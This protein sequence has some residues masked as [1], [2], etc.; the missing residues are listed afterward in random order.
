[1]CCLLVCVD[2]HQGFVTRG[3][4]TWLQYYLASHLFYEGFDTDLV[5]L[6]TSLG[7]KRGTLDMLSVDAHVAYAPFRDLR[8][9]TISSITLWVLWKVCCSHIPSAQRSSLTDTLQ[10][11]W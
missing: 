10:E 9:V 1:M 7:Y 5:F 11:I 4:V 6:L 3:S 2:I 8:F